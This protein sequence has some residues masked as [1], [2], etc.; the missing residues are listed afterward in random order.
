MEKTKKYKRI[1]L[2]VKGEDRLKSAF[3]M[4]ERK[5][6]HAFGKAI[7]NAEEQV[8]SCKEE[9][10]KLLFSLAEK[11]EQRDSLDS[12]FTQMIQKD[13]EAEEWADFKERLE[14]FKAMLDEEVEVI[15]EK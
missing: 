14:K 2:M 15:E 12:L 1:D 13:R 4:R 8:F 3:N 10:E 5:I 9:A 6:R 7:S 11:I